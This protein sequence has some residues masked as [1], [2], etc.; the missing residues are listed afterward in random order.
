M[1][2]YLISGLPIFYNN[3]GSSIERIPKDNNKFIINNYDTDIIEINI[4]KYNK[5][6]HYIINSNNTI[7]NKN[8]NKYSYISNKEFK[9]FNYS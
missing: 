7:S 2:K 6:L 8:V 5:F 3:I 4:D 9:L 1:S